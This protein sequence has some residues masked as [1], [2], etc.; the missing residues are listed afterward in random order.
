MQLV[1][2][3]I[4]LHCCVAIRLARDQLCKAQTN[5]KPESEAACRW[6]PFVPDT[7][8]Y[9]SN[10]KC[11]KKWLV[12][13]NNSWYLDGL[14]V[15][16]KNIY[17]FETLIISL[18]NFCQIIIFSR[19]I[20]FLCRILRLCRRAIFWSGKPSRKCRVR[21]VW[22]YV[23]TIAVFTIKIFILWRV[24][25]YLQAKT[26][27]H[28]HAVPHHNTVFWPTLFCVNKIKEYE[29]VCKSKRK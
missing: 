2:T 25:K 8:L 9:Q 10:G 19:E 14:S 18:I 7:F 24:T 28:F 12:A 29:K 26:C 4:V 20:Y 17:P 23:T 22:K 1:S 16:K 21:E 27:W 3:I 11:S 13:K 6:P 5:C 15:D